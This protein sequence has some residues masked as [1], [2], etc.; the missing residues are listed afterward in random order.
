MK[1]FVDKIF[2]IIK[3]KNSQDHIIV[4]QASELIWELAKANNQLLKDY[5]REILEIFDSDDFF[6]CNIQTLKV[7]SRLI[8]T[9][10]DVTKIDILTEYF[11]S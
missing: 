7:W 11:D 9:T 5:K 10:L 3:S 2:L 6:N 1:P 8:D 4:E